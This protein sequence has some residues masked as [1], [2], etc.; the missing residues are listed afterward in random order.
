MQGYFND[1]L[2]SSNPDEE[3]ISQVTET[4]S[5]RLPDDMKE[6]LEAPFTVA[7]VKDAVFSSGPTK[8]PGPDGFHGL[9]YQKMWDIVGPDVTKTCLDILNYGGSIVDLNVTQIVLIPKVKMR[10]RVVLRY[11]RT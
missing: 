11:Q 4:I 10:F 1:I 9:F 2:C 8:A 5:K 7:D 3:I 6:A